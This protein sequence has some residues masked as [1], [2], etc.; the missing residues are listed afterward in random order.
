MKR[1]KHKRGTLKKDDETEQSIRKA[2]RCMKELQKVG[3]VRVYGKRTKWSRLINQLNRRN[4][5]GIL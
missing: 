5:L 3:E 2:E 1:K 4:L